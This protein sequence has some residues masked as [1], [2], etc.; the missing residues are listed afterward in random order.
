M[1]D[2]D[3]DFLSMQQA[4]EMLCIKRQTLHLWTKKNRENPNVKCPPYSR[5]GSRF[6]FKKEDIEKFIEESIVLYR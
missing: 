4:A 1:S 6:R 3:L 5:I 2:Q